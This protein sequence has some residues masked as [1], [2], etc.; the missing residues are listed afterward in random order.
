MRQRGKEF[1]AASGRPIC[2]GAETAIAVAEQ[3]AAPL[4][5]L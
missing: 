4:N 3:F 5:A 2:L 1:K